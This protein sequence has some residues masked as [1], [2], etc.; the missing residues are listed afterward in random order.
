MQ[1]LNMEMSTTPSALVLNAQATAAA[2]PFG[3]LC[4]EIRKAIIELHEQRINCPERQILTFGEQGQMSSLP[5][6]SYDLGVHKLV[7]CLPHN[8]RLNLPAIH[9][10]VTAW[11]V[12]TGQLCAQLDGITVTARRTAALS[13]VAM[14]LLCDSD[15]PRVCIIGTGAQAEGHLRA[16]EAMYP[17][18][19]VEIKGVDQAQA[20]AFCSR[21]QHS[22]LPLRPM[23]ADSYDGVQVVITT[24]NSY[25]PVYHCPPTKERL[26]IGVGAFLPEMAE[27]AADTV[28]GSALYIDEPRGG[29]LEAGDYL[30]AEVNWDTVSSLAHAISGNVDFELPRMFKCV[31]GAAFD[32]AAVRC[33]L[34]Q[35]RGSRQ[36]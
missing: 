35:M 32:L 24:T 6:S 34:H 20:E 5:A 25:T 17:L 22:T 10:V 18:G 30:Q 23:A 11:D 33:A 31:G 1:T 16:L 27:Y 2:L 26:L 21:N 29:R 8:H 15:R 13:M 7:T 28:K 14:Q 9:G 12:Q 36:R 4:T 19:S 3:P